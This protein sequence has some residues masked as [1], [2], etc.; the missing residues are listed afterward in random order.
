MSD[1]VVECRQCKAPFKKRGEQKFCSSHCRTVFFVAVKAASPLEGYCRKVGMDLEKRG[2][3]WVTTCAFHNETT[4]S[5]TVYQDDHFYCYGCDKTGDVLDLCMEL[6]HLTRMEAAEKLS[7]GSVPEMIV[8]PR[9]KKVNSPPY[10]FTQSDEK[11]IEASCNRLSQDRSLIERICRKRPEW[12][13]DAILALSLEGDLGYEDNCLFGELSGPAVLFFY[14]HGI[15]ARWKNKIVRWIRG[16]PNGTCWRQSAMR[17]SHQRVY[18][19]EGETDAITA[20]S[21]GLESESSIVLGLASA[22]TVPDPD[23]FHDKEIIAIPDADPAGRKSE[24][25]LRSILGP[26]VA[27]KFSTFGLEVLFHG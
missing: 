22:L 27:R 6:E 3:S 4:P 16:A 26:P 12:S 13:A 23:P 15:K 18:V 9:E 19:T 24:Q 14:S 10:S 21:V 20:V 17:A 1:Q 2:V 7:G 8:L 5:F 25:K 11:R